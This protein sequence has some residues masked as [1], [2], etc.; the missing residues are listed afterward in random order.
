M[1]RMGARPGAGVK[2]PVLVLIARFPR[3]S[4]SSRHRAV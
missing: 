2:V 1:V 3:S 4:S